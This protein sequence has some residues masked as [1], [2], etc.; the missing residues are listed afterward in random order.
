MFKKILVLTLIGIYWI[1]SLKANDGFSIKYQPMVND[2][3]KAEFRVTKGGCAPFTISL[4]SLQTADYYIWKLGDGSIAEGTNSIYHTYNQPGTYNISL[5]VESAISCNKADTLIRTVE[6]RNPPSLDFDFSPSNPGPNE[7]VKFS[8]LITS[9][10]WEYS[11]VV[12]DQAPIKEDDFHYTFDDIGEY[13]VCLK[14]FEDISSCSSEFCKTVTVTKS[15]LLEVPTAFT[16]NQD[17]FND[18]FIISAKGIESFECSVFDRIGQRV[19]YTKDMMEGWN[20]EYKGTKLR[21]EMYIFFIKAIRT[22]GEVLTKQGSV[23]LIR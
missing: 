14:A 5:I 22:D 7:E 13:T 4:Q 20:G 19:F 8:N 17:G 21:S 9:S 12:D 2:S 6:V 1:V 16:P 10:A 18:E 23:F 3:V 15:Y 11:W